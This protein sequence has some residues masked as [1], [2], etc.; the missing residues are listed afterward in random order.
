MSGV[1]FAFLALVVARGIS[2]FEERAFSAGRALL[3][4]GAEHAELE[5]R[6]G[7]RDLPTVASRFAADGDIAAQVRSL[8]QLMSRAPAGSA[9]ATRLK[10]RMSQLAKKLNERITEMRTAPAPDSPA[11]FDAI[12]VTDASGTVLV[13]DSPNFRTGMSLK[14]PEASEEGEEIAPSATPAPAVL[15]GTD[16]LLRGAESGPVSATLIV[17]KEQKRDVLWTGAAPVSVR[18]KFYGIVV[19]ER[20][21]KALPQPSGVNA[22]L[23][24]DDQVQMGR[25][26]DG[27]TPG[28]PTEKEPFLLV[29]KTASS[30]VPVLGDVPIAPMFTS[31]RGVGVWAMAFSVS[32]E[33]PNAVGFVLTDV[34]PLFSDLGGF[35]L[36]TCLLALI[37]WLV[38]VTMIV[39][40]GRQVMGGL[41]YISDFLGKLHQGTAT[42]SRINE[43]KIPSSLHRLARLINKTLERSGTHVAP[44]AGA[45][46]LD[47]VLKAQDTPNT[48]EID[49][50]AID[51]S[52]NLGETEEAAEPAHDDLSAVDDFDPFNATGEIQVRSSGDHDLLGEAGAVL[53][54]AV[55]SEEM[56]ADVVGGAVPPEPA[57]LEMV[58]DEDVSDATADAMPIEESA[59]PP[60][61]LRAGSAVADLFSKTNGSAETADSAILEDSERV[62]STLDPLEA[63][64]REVFEQFV[65]ARE[66]CGE[67]TAEL[68]FE[69]FSTKLDKSREAVMSKHNC[70]EVKFSVYVK[71]GKAALKATPAR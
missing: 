3:V 52:G 2:A 14:R 37:A 1:V 65:S 32:P 18:N 9:I 70:A 5:L 12:T 19:V 10:P 53:P 27:Y 35:Q 50:T 22:M 57:E 25:A 71:N 51:N 61:P 47:E 13:T 17:G 45:P 21:L 16:A 38:H 58:D 60:Q 33:T 24:I 40:S 39:T 48:D 59:E 67:S 20:R 4:A 41:S 7:G 29:R 30:L 11:P 36:M 56:A 28:A 34:T 55:P 64:Y 49:F 69:K 54:D 46:S 26:P 66:S 62:G 42:E 15:A 6:G 63:H 8:G 43:R 44:I 68:T 31:E 23:V